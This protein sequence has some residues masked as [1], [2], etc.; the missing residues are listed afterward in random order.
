MASPNPLQTASD[1]HIRA[2]LIALCRKHRKI[3]REALTMLAHL[4]TF[5]A[6]R[7]QAK[8]AQQPTHSSVIGVKRKM[9]TSDDQEMSGQGGVSGGG[10]GSAEICVKCGAAFD[11]ETNNDKAC[12][13]HPD[14]GESSMLL[15]YSVSLLTPQQRTL[16]LTTKATS[17]P[18]T[19]RIVMA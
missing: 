5:E 3:E 15:R 10:G 16:N 8:N 4:E 12:R 11:S 7:I 13:S 2:T 6:A 19:T 18:T 1:K 9:A 14:D 17:G